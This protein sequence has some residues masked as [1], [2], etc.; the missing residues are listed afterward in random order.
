MTSS[1]SF[2]ENLRDGLALTDVPPDSKL[3]VAFSGGP[4]S[5]ALLAGLV[6]LRGDM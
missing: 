1:D 6:K 4:D 3:V 5:T 2:V